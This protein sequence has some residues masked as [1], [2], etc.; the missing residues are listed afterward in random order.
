MT[1]ATVLIP[2]H[3][4]AALLP[5]A[6]RSAL[7]Q[8]DASVE[9]FVVGDGVGDDTRAAVEPF[10][11]DQRVRFFDL[12]KGERYGERNRHLALA[13]AAGR[14]VC[15]LSDDDLLLPRHVATMFELLE[16]VPFA[17]SAPFFMKPDDVLVYAP[18][19]LSEETQLER[20]RHGSWN[21]VA[22]TGA[23][24]TL[25]AYRQ[26][27]WG[28]RP[29]PPGH[30][31]DYHMWL[32]FLELPDFRGVTGMELTHLRFPDPVWSMRPLA[33]RVSAIASWS[34]EIRDRES[35][36]HLE[37]RARRTVYRTAAA[38]SLEADAMGREADSLKQAMATVESSRIWRLRQ[39]LLTIRPIRAVVARLPAAR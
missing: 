18:C 35:V 34:A 33:E 14:I 3:R 24:H 11:A 32:Q 39:R 10:L 19:D 12:P 23:A 5:H 20:M 30:Q 31:T 7:A 4:H 16:D 6:V 38:M 17:Q 28:W 26:L 8:E 25:D 13:E 27:P 15:Y 1:D 36:L 9:L 37:R 29:A 22:L 2:T 21:P